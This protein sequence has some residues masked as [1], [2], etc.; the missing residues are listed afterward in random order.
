M[1]EIRVHLGSRGKPERRKRVHYPRA[2]GLS[3]NRYM[4]DPIV[5]LQAFS[6]FGWF[7]RGVTRKRSDR[8]IQPL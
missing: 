6:F 2:Y 5:I 7:R 3:L 8:G 1:V 4:A